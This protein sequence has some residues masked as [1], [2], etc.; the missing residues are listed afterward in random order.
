[1]SQASLWRPEVVPPQKQEPWLQRKEIN[2]LHARCSPWTDSFSGRLE[3]IVQFRQRPTRNPIAQGDGLLEVADA[4]AYLES[5]ATPSTKNA[6][7]AQYD[8]F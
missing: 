5:A 8:E 2:V 4:F 1:M 7:D 3:P 6:A